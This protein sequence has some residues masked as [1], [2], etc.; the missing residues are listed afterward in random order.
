MQRTL[1]CGRC[2]SEHSSWTDRLAGAEPSRT[3]AAHAAVRALRQR[4]LQ[5]D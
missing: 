3:R 5:L 2:A 1:P 4:A